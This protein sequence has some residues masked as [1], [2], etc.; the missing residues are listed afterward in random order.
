MLVVVA[1]TAAAT[2]TGL[3]SS[4]SSSSSSYK[5]SLSP[6]SSGRMLASAFTIR[7]V[8]KRAVV[9]LWSSSSSSSSNN[10]NN[11]NSSSSSSV[12]DVQQQQLLLEQYRNTNNKK[13]QVFAA[14]SGDGG[15]KVT[16][17]TVRNLVND[18][19]LQH[20]MTPTPTDAIGRTVVCGLLLANGIQTEQVVQITMNGAWFDVVWCGVLLWCGVMWRLNFSVAVLW[21]EIK[22]WYLSGKS[23]C[24][25]LTLPSLSLLVLFLLFTFRRRSSSWHCYHCWWRRNS[26]WLCRITH[27][28]A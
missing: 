1:A 6:S 18:M 2:A 9:R 3:L 16:A 10:H 22:S 28:R 11:V 20:S 24:F 21:K 14:I 8:P 17:A 13:D 19:S 23:T 26:P 4:S 25:G 15:I 7:S 12:H 27:A 5:T